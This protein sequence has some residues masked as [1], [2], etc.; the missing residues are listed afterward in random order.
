MGCQKGLF[1]KH[2]KDAQILLDQGDSVQALEVIDNLL[3]FSPNNPE[4]LR[5]KANIL[6][7]W[8]HFDESFILLQKILKI[9][10]TDEKIVNNFQT[11]MEEE[12]ASLVFSQ[13]T[14][15]GRWYFPFSAIRLFASLSVFIGCIFF[16]ISASQILSKP[17]GSLLLGISFVS[18]VLLPWLFSLFLSFRGIKRIFVGFDG[19]SVFYGFKS[20]FYSWNDMGQ[21]VIEYDPN[22]RNQYLRMI[23]YSKSTRQ[24]LLNFDISQRSSVIKARRHF[25]RLVSSY[26]G[27]VMYVTRG[28]ATENSHSWKGVDTVVERSRNDKAA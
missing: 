10:Q 27:N 19:I 7:S 26:L 11:R 5:L 28:K 24:P 13:L 8:G 22:L 14:P 15:L 6:D 4:A 2:I 9:A 20:A 3:S 16:L 17:N 1:M 21:M 25:V 12:R 18:L 23:I